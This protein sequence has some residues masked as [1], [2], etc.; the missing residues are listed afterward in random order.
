MDINGSR[1]QVDGSRGKGFLR[2][3]RA[4]MRICPGNLET[5][6]IKKLRKKSMFCFFFSVNS[7]KPIC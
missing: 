2:S 5:G 6:D 4:G 7:N 1:S 3:M